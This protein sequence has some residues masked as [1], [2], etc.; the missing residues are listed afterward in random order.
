MDTVAT[1]L[2]LG[3]SHPRT[4]D[5][6]DRLGLQP[7]RAVEPGERS[8]PRSAVRDE[9]GRRGCEAS[10]FCYLGSRATEHAAE[11]DRAL[12]SRLLGLPR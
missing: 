12:L 4:S 6:T 10:W 9:S 3:L 8:S 2:L 1:F 11:L 7:T 5:V